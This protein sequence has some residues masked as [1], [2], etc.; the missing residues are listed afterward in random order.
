MEGPE[1]I[2]EGTD[3]YGL[4]GV[5]KTASKNEIRKAYRKLARTFHPDHHGGDVR[6]E[7]EKKF[8]QINYAYVVLMDDEQ[9]AVYDIYGLE[10][11]KSNTCKELVK[12]YPTLDEVCSRSLPFQQS[13]HSGNLCSLP[14]HHCATVEEAS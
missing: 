13:L 11:L 9:R 8:V 6:G 7:A 12:R 5:K 2:E 1:E 10:A 4:L 14:V 3:L